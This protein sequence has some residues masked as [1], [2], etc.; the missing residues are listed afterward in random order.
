MCTRRALRSSLSAHPSH[1]GA[2]ALT[3]LSS[4]RASYLRLPFRGRRG[5]ILGPLL[6]AFSALPPPFCRPLGFATVSSCLMP[7]CA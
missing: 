3:V 4:A 1:D 2:C 5:L 7:V 6:S